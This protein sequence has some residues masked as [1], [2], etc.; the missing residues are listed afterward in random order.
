M[1]RIGEAMVFGLPRDESLNT[2]VDLGMGTGR[3]LRRLC[4]SFKASGHLVSAAVGVEEVD[5]L[6]TIAQVCLDPCSQIHHSFLQ[7][8][9]SE[10]GALQ[11]TGLDS[12]SFLFVHGDFSQWESWPF[13]EGGAEFFYMYD[14]AFTEALVVHV[15]GL[16]RKTPR[17]RRV[18]TTRCGE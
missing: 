11:G 14:F 17:L 9:Y 12:S 13:D 2:I 5:N 18:A 1:A 10:K 15:E 4:R 3:A 8:L 7:G 6:I 16:L